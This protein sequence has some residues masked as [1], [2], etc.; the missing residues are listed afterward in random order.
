MLGD[1]LPLGW[2]SA[3]LQAA[4]LLSKMKK[5]QETHL[6]KVGHEGGAHLSEAGRIQEPKGCPLLIWAREPP[7]LDYREG[8]GRDLSWRLGCSVRVQVHCARPANRCLQPQEVRMDGRGQVPLSRYSIFL[9]GP[10]RVGGPLEA[11]CQ[12]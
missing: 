6:R 2:L 9:P 5:L 3:L 12:H 11:E 7:K 10:D 4:R 8:R 1:R